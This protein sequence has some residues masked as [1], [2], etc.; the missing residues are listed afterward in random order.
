MERCLLIK[1]LITA[2]AGTAAGIGGFYAKQTTGAVIGA[3]VGGVLGWLLAP[4]CGGP[5]RLRPMPTAVQL[6]PEA[7]ATRS[8]PRLSYKQAPVVEP[9]CLPGEYYNTQISAC[10][11]VIK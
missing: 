2:G 5:V 8:L 6:A 1:L 11:P 3:G 4:G 10:M 7:Q 9:Q